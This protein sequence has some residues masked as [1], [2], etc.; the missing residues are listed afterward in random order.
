MG[1]KSPSSGVVTI[2]GLNP[3][4]YIKRNPKAI[5]FVPQNT[6]IVRGTLR[7]NLTWPINSENFTDSQI[8]NALSQ[9]AL[10]EFISTLPLGLDTILDPRG[11]NLSAGQRQRI[12]IAR[13]LIDDPE[14]L[15]LDEATSS[16]DSITEKI[17]VTNVLL[18][19][20]HLTRI[21]IAHRLATI[22]KADNIIVLERGQ[23]VASGNYLELSKLN[24]VT[25]T[26]L[27][28]LEDLK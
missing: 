8:Q 12:G 14:I 17:V 28:S 26:S 2:N 23:I 13:A 24:I 10:S 7:Q 6:E 18:N 22:E 5:R 9:A 4:T 15:I 3:A 19:L 16:L 27:A 11:S 25:D 21:V 20:T 1:I